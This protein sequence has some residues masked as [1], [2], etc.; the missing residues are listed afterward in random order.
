[1]SETLNDVNDGMDEKPKGLITP[2]LNQKL[3]NSKLMIKAGQGLWQEC[4]ELIA[5]G[6][7]PKHGHT[8]NSCFTAALKAGSVETLQVLMD[9]GVN[10]DDELFLGYPPI[11]HAA[12]LGLPHVITFLVEKGASIG[13]EW[14]F[15]GELQSPLHFAVSFH[16]P[17]SVQRLLELGADM[18]ENGIKKD[19]RGVMKK[20]LTPLEL[21]RGADCEGVF[22]SFLA[23]KE[24]SKALNDIESDIGHDIESE[25]PTPRSPRASS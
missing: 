17:A 4:R 23:R 10:P 8:P 22:R 12:A 20:Q 5:Q 11:F 18:N 6:A 21:A 2:Q 7:D 1:M 24:A 14:D 3:L 16:R 19:T 25:L 9:A 15:S 13:T